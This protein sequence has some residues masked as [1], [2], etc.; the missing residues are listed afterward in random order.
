MPQIQQNSKDLGSREIDGGGGGLDCIRISNYGGGG[1]ASEDNNGD[2]VKSNTGQG[3]EEEMAGYE[4]NDEFICKN[5]H[6]HEKQNLSFFLRHNYNYSLYIFEN[7]R[8][9]NL[10]NFTESTLSLLQLHILKNSSIN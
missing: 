8:A 7:R 1:G 3:L 4:R 5:G 2:G 10:C 9:F 6:E